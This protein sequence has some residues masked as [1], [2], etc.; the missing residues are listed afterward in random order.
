MVVAVPGYDTNPL[1]R[2]HHETV[3]YQKETPKGRKLIQT[4]FP[5]VEKW[6]DDQEPVQVRG[7]VLGWGWRIS[8]LLDRYLAGGIAACDSIQSN[9]LR[10]SQKKYSG[11]IVLWS[12][13]LGLEK[14]LLGFHPSLPN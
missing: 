13:R 3:L 14:N 9:L 7:G 8:K 10:R 1:E 11:T 2:L 5:M 4:F 12:Q 6:L